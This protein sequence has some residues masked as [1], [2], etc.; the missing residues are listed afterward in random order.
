MTEKYRKFKLSDDLT[1]KERAMMKDIEFDFDPSSFGAYVICDPNWYNEL[2][3]N[4]T[5]DTL[6][7][8]FRYGNYRADG[9]CDCFVS[10]EGEFFVSESEMESGICIEWPL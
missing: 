1:P 2:P 6:P 8:S 7:V 5:T 4:C 10:P 9:V 3:D